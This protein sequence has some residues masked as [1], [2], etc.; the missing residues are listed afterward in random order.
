MHGPGVAVVPSEKK[1]ILDASRGCGVLAKHES[2][3]AAVRHAIDGSTTEA[4]WYFSD[5]FHEC[6]DA[7]TWTAHRHWIRWFCT[8]A[9]SKAS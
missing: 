2:A 1:S 3:A 4:G 7:Q 8:I 5:E 9:R 6:D